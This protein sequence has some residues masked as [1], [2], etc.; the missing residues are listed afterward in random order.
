MA[1]KNAVVL[2]IWRKIESIGPWTIAWRK[3]KQNRVANGW[4]DYFCI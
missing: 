3:F 4:F 1:K 2:R